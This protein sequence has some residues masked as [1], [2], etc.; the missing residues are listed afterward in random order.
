MRNVN[1]TRLTIHNEFDLKSID[2]RN[3]IQIIL[4]ILK[5]K[6]V[7]IVIFQM[8]FGT[9]KYKYFGRIIALDHT[10]RLVQ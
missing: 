8:Y 3:W 6:C 9:G 5:Y 1:Y 7:V 2:I 10:V 4:Y